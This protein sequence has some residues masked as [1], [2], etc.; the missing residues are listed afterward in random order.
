ME[1]AAQ[2]MWLVMQSEAPELCLERTKICS[3]VVC[4]VV[5]VVAC[6]QVEVGNT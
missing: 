4:S 3:A 2:C 1:G 5:A 6:V